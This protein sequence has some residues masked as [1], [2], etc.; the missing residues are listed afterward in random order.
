[1]I[2][3]DFKNLYFVGYRGE[4]GNCLIDYGQK[5]IA[6][7]QHDLYKWGSNII[8]KTLPFLYHLFPYMSF[9]GV[10]MGEFSL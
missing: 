8:W 9:L 5:Y 1:M 4:E 10:I 3:S 2:T 6:R 7:L